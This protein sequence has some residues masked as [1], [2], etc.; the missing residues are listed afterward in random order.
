[1]FNNEIFKSRFTN[2]LFSFSIAACILLTVVP[3]MKI[4]YID[5]DVQY[6]NYNKD[7]NRVIEIK[8]IVT[9]KNVSI[10]KNLLSD[11]SYNPEDMYL[12]YD[13][14]EESK[15]E[16]NRQQKEKE[17]KEN[18]AKK[19]SSVEL[20]S[21]SVATLNLPVLGDSCF[22]GYMCMHMVT[23][24]SS[25]QWKFLH[26]GVYNIYADDNGFMRYNNYYIIALA[27]YYTNHKIGG[28]FRI[29]LSSGV[30]FDAIVGDEKSDI[31]TDESKMYRP[32]GSDR[33]EIVEFVIACGE[34]S[35]T[36]TKY[37]TMST[38]DKQSGDLSAL[39]FQGNVVKIERLDNSS[40]VDSLYR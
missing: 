39:N 23:S 16:M 3:I 25:Y 1:M 6:F 26:S 13:K 19:Y 29:T 40:V 34:Y 24:V 28:T 36:C 31:D 7:Y 18:N 11:I 4:K 20:T 15:K 30:V 14:L 27:S 35:K 21:T 9:L 8:S 12:D 33:G 2:A 22:K 10:T 37:N 32:K 17:G 38:F 5:E